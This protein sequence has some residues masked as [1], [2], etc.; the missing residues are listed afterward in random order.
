MV[1]RVTT[2]LATPDHIISHTSCPPTLTCV[3][4]HLTRTV[5]ERVSRYQHFTVNVL[6]AFTD[7][8]SEGEH[9][10]DDIE[11]ELVG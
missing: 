6:S 7:I 2:K 8:S 9:E 10:P 4:L 5:A 3:E 11:A 1:G